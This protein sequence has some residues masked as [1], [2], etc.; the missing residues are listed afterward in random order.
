MKYPLSNGDI[1]VVRGD[2]R[3]TSKKKKK[4]KGLLKPKCG[5]EDH[6]HFA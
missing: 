2:E 4:M 1:G 5:R 3:T 6:V